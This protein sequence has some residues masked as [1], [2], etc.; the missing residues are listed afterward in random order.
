[1]ADEDRTRADPGAGDAPPKHRSGAGTFGQTRAV[2]RR[3]ARARRRRR[4]AVE[5]AAVL[6]CLVVLVAYLG[7][8]SDPEPGDGQGV[9]PAM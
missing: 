4:W 1:M 5:G 8:R 7:S 3:V 2:L 9:A 6:A